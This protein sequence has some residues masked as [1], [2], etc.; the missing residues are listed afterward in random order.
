[1][2][3]Y[4]LVTLLLSHQIYANGRIEKVKNGQALVNFAGSEY[5]PKVGDKL[6]VF[7]DGEKTGEAEI[8]QFKDSR[9]K[10]KILSG[11]MIEE[12]VVKPGK[13]RPKRSQAERK[14]PQGPQAAQQIGFNVGYGADFQTVTTTGL[15]V[16][17]AGNGFSARGTFLYPILKQF[18]LL[19]RLGVERFQTSGVVNGVNLSTEINYFVTDIL[20][21]YDYNIGDRKNLFLL[22]GLGIHLPFSKKSGFLNENKI[23]TT[24]ALYLGGGG[25]FPITEQFSGNVSAE[26]VYF[27]PSSDVKTYIMAVRVGLSKP[28]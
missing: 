12:S 11:D 17:S 4:I 9:A 6:D 27:P 24:T 15:N 19:G 28:F 8:I 2:L 16:N 20:F 23:G 13:N 7:T 25:S 18:S 21:T 3:R 26:Y 5:S 14:K 22:S 1:M 10:V